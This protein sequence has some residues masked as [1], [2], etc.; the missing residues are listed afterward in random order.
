MSAPPT[1]PLAPANAA[2]RRP[3]PAELLEAWQGQLTL[4]GRTSPQY[5]RAAA[6][7][8]NRWRDPQMWAVEPLEARLAV[9]DHTRPF[10]AF[11]M[12][13]GWLRPGYDYLVRRKLATIWRDLAYSPM[14]VDV[15]RF[16]AAAAELGYRPSVARAV[17]SQ[18]VV[19]VLIQT[20]RPLRGL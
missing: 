13:W 19:R 4:T 5:R 16:S 15:D 10:L 11:L 1:T 12:V 6:T 14:A 20:G 8:L 17:A 2:C 7:F 18:A 3:E 9:D